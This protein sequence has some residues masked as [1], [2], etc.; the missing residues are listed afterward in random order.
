MKR[1]TLILSLGLLVSL[2]V[3]ALT[4][5]Q[6]ATWEVDPV[7]SDVSF[8]V[9]HFLTPVPG[10]F[11]DFSGAI[12]YDPANAA[13]SRVELTVQAASIDTGNEQRDGHLRSPDFFDV[14]KYPTLSFKST[15]VKS[16]GAGELHVTGDFNLHGV[17][18][19][20]TVPVEVLGV[21]D[22]PMGPRAGFVAEFKID[23]KDY[24]ITWNRAL[25]QGGAI[26]GDEVKISI[27][28]EAKP[29]AA[30]E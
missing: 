17:T 24:G 14:E 8:S 4:M 27:A 19:S 11:A 6:A 15:D 7:H 30:S 29:P 5:A 20:I 16:A 23:R 10:R 3:P 12:V 9:R 1:P 25:D 2:L 21:M 18:K 28:V 13:G 26:L 22:T